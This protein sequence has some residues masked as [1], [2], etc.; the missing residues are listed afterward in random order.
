MEIKLITHLKIVTLILSLMF[1]SLYGQDTKDNSVLS[2][3]DKIQIT[4]SDI[5]FRDTQK[6]ETNIYEI[7]EDGQIY[8]PLLGEINLENRTIHDSEKIL[9][10]KLKKYFTNPFISI[11]IVDKM[12]NTIILYGEV[13][14]VGVYQVE[15]GKKVAEFIIEK[16][17]T[18]PNADLSEITILHLNGQ[19][20]LFNMIDYLYANKIEENIELQNGDK[21]IV[22]KLADKRIYSRYSD[23]Y[24]LQYGNV[25]EIAIN[26][27]SARQINPDETETCPIDNNGDIYHKLLGNVHVGGMSI[28]KTK[29]LLEEKA[30]QYML[31]PIVDISVVTVSHKSVYVFGEIENSGIHP[32]RGNLRLADFLANTCKITKNADYD[33]IIITR[34]NGDKLKFNLEDFLFKRKDKNNIYLADGDRIIVLPRKRG[35]VWELSEY[36]RPYYYIIQL[37]ASALSV[38]YISTTR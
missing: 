38:Y 27:T 10:I 34:K 15:H 4:Y 12:S 23:N 25:L 29:M 33:E 37:V 5:N 21:V 3:G 36:I 20:S 17:G 35:F 19:S 7:M 1:I 16:G 13:S 31:T 30:S 22:H 18:L 8:H 26:E 11:K 2:I 28:L 9:Q 24:I 14:S 32:I 6:V